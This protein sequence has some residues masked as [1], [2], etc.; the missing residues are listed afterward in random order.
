MTMHYTPPQDTLVPHKDPADCPKVQTHNSEGLHNA[1][2]CRELAWENIRTISNHF[3]PAALAL[4]EQMHSIE[5]RLEWY[6]S[7]GRRYPE[8]Y[9]CFK[10]RTPGCPS[11]EELDKVK[12]KSVRQLDKRMLKL[13]QDRYYEL[14][15][16][17]HARYHEAKVCLLKHHDKKNFKLQ[18]PVNMV[19][20][21]DKYYFADDCK[22]LE[23]KV[24]FTHLEDYLKHVTRRITGDSRIE[25]VGGKESYERLVKSLL[26]KHW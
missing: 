26:A 16:E 20:I 19:K 11:H 24:P 3:N 10:E 14:L 4:W 17:Q 12:T 7:C 15:R 8:L 23:E 2:E 5:I 22:Q 9:E 13:V 1:A 6:R 25:Y 21:W 18:R